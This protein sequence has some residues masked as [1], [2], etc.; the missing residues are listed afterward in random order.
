[1]KKTKKRILLCGIITVFAAVNMVVAVSNEKHKTLFKTENA[2][3][4]VVDWY[5]I[6]YNIWESINQNNNDIVYKYNTRTGLKCAPVNIFS[7]KYA[8][9]SSQAQTLDANLG[10]KGNMTHAAGEVSGQVNTNYDA[11]RYYN[12]NYEYEYAVEIF[13]NGNDWMLKTCEPCSA[14]DPD[15]IGKNCTNYD[16]CAE[17]INSRASAYRNALGL[18]V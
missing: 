12:N 6:F 8:Y 9:N 14:S 5:L 1:M 4:S 17:A 13:L 18:N 7:G 3:A 10:F 15:V 11:T 16:E 2:E